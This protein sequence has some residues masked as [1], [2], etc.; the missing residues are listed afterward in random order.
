MNIALLNLNCKQCY[1]DSVNNLAMHIGTLLKRLMRDRGVTTKAMAA[2]CEV[3]PGAVSNWFATGRISKE[4][5]AQAAHLLGVSTDD[6]I[7]GA[8]G[9]GTNQ[10]IALDNNPLYPAIRRVKLKA[11]AGASGFSVDY[12]QEDDGQPVV[13]RA[14]W[15][16]MKGYRP[17]KML[18]LRVK[19]ESMV[20]ALYEDDLIII[21][22]MSTTP[23]DGTA[24]LVNYEG[25]IVVKRLVRDDGMWWLTSDNPDQRRYGR[26]ICNSAT[27]IIGEAVYRQ[28]ER[29]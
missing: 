7:S 15:Y 25:E 23:K 4:N 26:K 29:I 10:E 5:L 19:G 28:T 9:D 11:Q 21:N 2:H 16:K 20:P 27:E 18:A 14:D 6:L 13:F 22:T 24:F 12:G 1:V 8:A 17:E 3:S